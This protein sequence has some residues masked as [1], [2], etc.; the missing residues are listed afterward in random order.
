MSFPLC[1]GDE[2]VNQAEFEQL[3][4]GEQE[5]IQRLSAFS[6]SPR[7]WE[8][9]RALRGRKYTVR[10]AAAGAWR[11]AGYGGRGSLTQAD[12]AGLLGI[13]R[14][15]LI[16]MLQEPA[17]Q[18]AA[19]ALQMEWLNER[20][21]SVD[22]AL[23]RKAELGDVAAVKLWYQRARVILAE[24]NTEAGQDNWMAALEQARAEAAEE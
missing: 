3:P 11:A 24:A 1:L 22:D 2:K 4:L 20:V 15:T 9:Y 10:H 5:F 21:P 23:Y 16:R 6:L 13:S 19:L 17:L 7:F 8:G 14:R 12:F 18:T